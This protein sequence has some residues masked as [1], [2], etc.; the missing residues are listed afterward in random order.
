MQEELNKLYNQVYNDISSKES[1]GLVQTIEQNLELVE[2]TDFTDREDLKKA[3][4]LLSDYSIALFNDGYLKKSVTYLNKSIIQIEKHY[5]K[6]HDLNIWNDPMYEALIW[7]RGQAN[8][9]LRKTQIAKLDLVN[10]VNHNPENDKYRNWLK[11][12]SNRKLIII[13]W[14]FAV[15]AIGCIVLSFIMTPEDGI[16]NMLAIYG[17]II[18]LVGGLTTNFIRKKRMKIK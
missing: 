15:F 2:K 7:N 5:S 1:K 6:L 17:I 16:I 11:A 8:F 14:T 9:L 10:L 18:C 12:C 3:T 4:R 13:E